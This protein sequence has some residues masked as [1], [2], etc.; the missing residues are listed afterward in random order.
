MRA[1]QTA[2]PS[3]WTMDSLPG[4]LRCGMVGSPILA[5]WDMRS[6]NRLVHA[7]DYVLKRPDAR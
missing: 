1:I 7:Y 2:K 3:L 4:E 6:R 5:D